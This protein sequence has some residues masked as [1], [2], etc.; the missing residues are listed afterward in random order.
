VTKRPGPTQLPCFWYCKHMQNYIV[1]Y[2][3]PVLV[4]MALIVVF[5][6]QYR[7]GAKFKSVALICIGFLLGWISAYLSLF[8]FHLYK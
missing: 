7:S 2:T 4:I 5:A 8:V 6:H 1:H 3:I